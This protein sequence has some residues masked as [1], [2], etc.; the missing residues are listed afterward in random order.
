MK[1]K[2][3]LAAIFCFASSGLAQN[4][5]TLLPGQEAIIS[6]HFNGPTIVNGNVPDLLALEIGGGVPFGSHISGT[7]YSLL[8]GTALLGTATRSEPYSLAGQAFRSL[9]NPLPGFTPAPSVPVDFSS[10][11]DGSIQGRLVYEPL[12]TNPTT[13]DW[14]EAEFELYLLR[15]YDY[16]SGSRMPDPIIDSVQVIAV[17]EPS[18]AAL[19]ATALVFAVRRL[20]R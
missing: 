18:A 1:L 5:Y 3:M 15:Q 17:P 7:A 4:Y 10:I 8:D 12:F 2:L 19:I 14:V 20:R 13:D 9:E 11:R 16:N 6:F